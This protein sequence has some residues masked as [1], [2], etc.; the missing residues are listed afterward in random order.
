IAQALQLAYGGKDPWL[1]A[2]HTLISLSRLADRSLIA[3]SELTELFNAYE[4]LRHLEH[5]LQME[6]GMQTH[7]VP[8]D[9]E[10]RNLVARRMRCGDVKGFN[11]EIKKHTANVHRVFER[12]FR[13]SPKETEIRGADGPQSLKSGRDAIPLVSD[14]GSVTMEETVAE[15]PTHD[16]VYS[17]VGSQRKSISDPKEHRTGFDDVARLPEKTAPDALWSRKSY[18]EQLSDALITESDFRHRLGAFRR[19]WAE[20][21]GQI[22]S[23]EL[24]GSIDV[25]TAKRAQ[26]ALAEASIDVALDLTRDELSRR[27]M[28]PIDKLSVAV[29]GLGKLGGG[30]VDYGSDLDLVLVH[31]DKTA[32]ILPT[33]TTAEFYGRAA[34][35][36][37]TALSSM[38]RDGSVYRVDLRLRPYG[39]NGQSVISAAALLDYMRETAA[40]W[41]W[42]A[43]VKVRAVAGDRESGIDVER[44]VREIV[45]ARAAAADPDELARETRRV[46]SLLEKEKTGG[47][48]SKD[49]DIK[50]GTGGMLDV[51]FA[52][53]YLQLRDNV[54]DNSDD[55]STEFMLGRLSHLGSFSTSDYESFLLGYRFLSLLDHNLRL[56]VGRTTRLP[57]ANQKALD[58]VSHRM[59]LNSASDLVEQLTLHRL[60]IRQAF[61]NILG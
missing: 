46:R 57:V 49:I 2:P 31:D 41:E 4:F 59:N 54:P 27:H 51:Y 16:P 50:Y 28:T 53:R 45:H 33:Q 48:R 44:W 29:I 5:V 40:I 3:E 42:L 8:G 32:V 30:A 17:S 43:Y 26:T 12:V 11:S 56:T 35:L 23:R 60:N 25:T 39:K 38:T 6:N 1:R 37:V 61:E 24:S 18:F 14:G 19:R 22:R 47:R 7:T 58:I 34:Q 9:L 55:R 20:M 52:M 21:L 13:G 15:P 10:Q 36:F